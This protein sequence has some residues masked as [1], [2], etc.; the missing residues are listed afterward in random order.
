MSIATA[1]D[2]SRNRALFPAALLAIIVATS[3]L[4]TLVGWYAVV[5]QKY[6]GLADIALQ[7]IACA[8]VATVAAQGPT[9]GIGTRILILLATGMASAIGVVASS[10][11]EAARRGVF[12]VWIVSALWGLACV[13][14][15]ARAL[16][17]SSNAGSRWR[18][19]WM[20]LR[21]SF[22]GV[23]MDLAWAFALV[24]PVLF[25]CSFDGAWAL[26]LVAA[27]ID[28]YLLS[29]LRRSR[30]SERF[31]DLLDLAPMFGLGTFF[32]VASIFVM[33]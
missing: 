1:I 32:I 22:T 10:D 11:V 14:R 17:K 16:W 18:W 4:A 6:G 9:T 26:A 27:P 20:F 29:Y 21:L 19:T 5:D 12:L 24:S 15:I 3:P 31:Q 28:F 8:S 25:A 33:G 13:P 23:G 30:S 7:W 2:S